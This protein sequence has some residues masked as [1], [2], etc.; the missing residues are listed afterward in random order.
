MEQTSHDN[1]VLA[2]LDVSHL[3]ISDV[4]YSLPASPTEI[5]DTG[6][7]VIVQQVR[8]GVWSVKAAGTD[9]GVS[10]LSRIFVLVIYFLGQNLIQCHCFGTNRETL[11]ALDSSTPST[12]VTSRQPFTSKNWS[13]GTTTARV[14]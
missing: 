7:S 9:I 11:I 5:G 14:D 13:G 2:T 1:N 8:E 10:Q 4:V 6:D 12:L 3:E